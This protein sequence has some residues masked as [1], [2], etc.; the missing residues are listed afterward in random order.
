[1]MQMD[2]EGVVL[3]KRR[4][5]GEGKRC[6]ISNQTHRYREQTRG[7][8]RKGWGWTKWVKGAKR[9]KTQL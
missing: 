6:V 7:G 1:M 9:Y 8:Q 5:S 4:Q 2:P 3:R